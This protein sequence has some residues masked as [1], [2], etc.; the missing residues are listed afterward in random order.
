[1]TFEAW[2]LRHDPGQRWAYFSDMRPDEALIFKTHDTEPGKAH[3]VPHGA[4]DDPGCPAGA[5][6]RASIEMRGIAYW[7]A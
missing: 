7:F 3:C 1:M 4:F 6:P 2:L 5:T